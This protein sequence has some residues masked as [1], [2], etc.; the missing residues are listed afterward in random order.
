MARK[1]SMSVRT[2]TRRFHEQTGT[3]PR[4]YRHALRARSGPLGPA[5]ARD[6]RGCVRASASARH[7]STRN[8]A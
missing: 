3:S 1:A 6:V 4:Q 8:D 5:R 7:S 2:L